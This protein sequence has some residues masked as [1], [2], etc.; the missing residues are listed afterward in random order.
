MVTRC[1]NCGELIEASSSGRLPPWCL[2]CGATVGDATKTVSAEVAVAQDGPES[3]HVGSPSRQPDAWRSEDF[4]ETRPIGVYNFSLRG[5]L[6]KVGPGILL[7]GIFGALAAGAFFLALTRPNAGTTLPGLLMAGFAVGFLVYSFAG[8]GKC[9]RRVELFAD[10]VRWHGPKGIGRLA[11]ENVEAV[12]R[13]EIVLNGFPISELKLV[14]RTGR[15]AVFDLTIERYGELAGFIQ[16]RCAEVMRPRKRE[17]AV[18]CAADFG[19]V[20]VSPAGV[21]V[22]GSLF[23]WESVARYTIARGRLCF[24]FG[25]HGSQAIPLS[26]IPN[27]LVLLSLM[28]EFAMAARQESSEQATVCS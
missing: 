22:G 11:W 20:R 12:Y 25:W 17:Q 8:R 3:P 16:G 18:T 21:C 10:G 26:A 19:P 4:D 14:G 27:Y 2:C 23:P 24:Q 28:D 1:T 9:L 15:E 7:A 5:Y 13:S 6:H